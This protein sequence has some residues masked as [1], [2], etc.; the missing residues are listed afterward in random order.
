MIKNRIHSALEWLEATPFL[1]WVL[2]AFLVAYVLFFVVPIFLG[3]TAMQS[4]QV[5]PTISPIGTDL[6]QTLNFLKAW[7]GGQ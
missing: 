6:R 7:L 5:V 1:W 4:P 2:A 3:G